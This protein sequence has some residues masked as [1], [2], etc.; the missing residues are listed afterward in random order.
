MGYDELSLTGQMDI[1]RCICLPSQIQN[2]IYIKSSSNKI[3]LD[4]P[5]ELSNEELRA[6]EMANAPSSLR[7]SNSRIHFFIKCIPGVLSFFLIGACAFT[8]PIVTNPS[9][10]QSNFSKYCIYFY[11]LLGIIIVILAA[12]LDYHVV[13]RIPNYVADHN[14][15]TKK[16]HIIHFFVTQLI[17]IPIIIIV[18]TFAFLF[19]DMIINN[20]F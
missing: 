20:I 16:G 1:E 11:I 8:Y 6:N 2:D 5:P 19:M 17:L 3:M 12:H 14:G 13:K 9:I 18:T 10:P 15:L 4:Q 7:N